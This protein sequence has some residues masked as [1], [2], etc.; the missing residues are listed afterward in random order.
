MYIKDLSL[1]YYLP[2]AHNKNAYYYYDDNYF[3]CAEKVDK[4]FIL[5]D[6]TEIFKS[7]LGIRKIW[8]FDKYHKVIYI[9][10]NGGVM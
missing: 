10:C 7:A 4:L 6:Y 1:I 5:E 2:T 8:Y 9:Q 3:I